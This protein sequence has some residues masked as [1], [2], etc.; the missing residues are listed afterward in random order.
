MKRDDLVAALS[1]L[2]DGNVSAVQ[3]ALYI[4]PEG[5]YV[6]EISLHMTEKRRAGRVNISTH[7]S[8]PAVLSLYGLGQE[9]DERNLA[10]IYER[11]GLRLVELAGE[12]MNRS[13]T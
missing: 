12:M 4:V 10:E 9:L 1:A 8:G 7:V 13:S 3:M 5:A 2:L 11:V 6:H